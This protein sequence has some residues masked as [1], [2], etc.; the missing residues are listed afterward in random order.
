MNGISAFLT[1]NQPEWF[2]EAG[3][4]EAPIIVQYYLALS[5]TSPELTEGDIVGLGGDCPKKSKI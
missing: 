3:V 2:L 4:F 5:I 1:V